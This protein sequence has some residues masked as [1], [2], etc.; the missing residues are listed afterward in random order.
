MQKRRARKEQSADEP[1]ADRDQTDLAEGKGW[2]KPGPKDK[3]KGL[4]VEK[5]P[6]CDH[7]FDPASDRLRAEPRWVMIGE[8]AAFLPK[9]MERCDGCQKPGESKR[10]DSYWDAARFEKCPRCGKVQSGHFATLWCYEKQGITPGGRVDP[11][12]PKPGQAG[13]GQDQPAD[14]VLDR[15]P[16]N[17]LR[18]DEFE[19]S[20]PLEKRF[21]DA[22]EDVVRR[23]CPAWV[24]ALV[25]AAFQ[26][27]KNNPDSPLLRLIFADAKQMKLDAYQVLRSRI[28]EQDYPP[29]YGKEFLARWGE[30]RC[31]IADVLRT[32]LR[33]PDDGH[34]AQADDAEQTNE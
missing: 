28:P 10:A 26:D 31:E 22:L 7:T 12:A 13:G 25:S 4:Y 16:S 15:T 6:G 3:G 21:A 27:W 8:G 34:G 1:S 24:V 17:G 9:R 18:S 29:Q 30:W 14:S 23:G 19:V 11:H 32:V 33:P 5:C 2:Q 20:L